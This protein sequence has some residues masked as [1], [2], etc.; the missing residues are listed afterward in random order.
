MKKIVLLIIM[1]A[2]ATIVFCE[3]TYSDSLLQAAK[4]GDATAQYILGAH[5]FKGEGVDR[6]YKEAV[7]WYRLAAEQGDDFAQFNLG[8]CYYKGE[9]VVQSYKDAYF[10]ALIA[11]ANGVE[12]AKELSYKAEKK[13]SSEDISQIQSK[14]SQWFETHNN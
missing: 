1:L 9:G 4:R 10:W 13:L 2:A 7:K 3:I 11:A 14:A 12:A 8:L 5:Y 6:D